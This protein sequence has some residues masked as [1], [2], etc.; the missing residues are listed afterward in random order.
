[1]LCDRFKL[2]PWQIDDLTPEELAVFREYV[3]HQ[4]QRERDG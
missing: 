3:K 4:L 1:M 2:L